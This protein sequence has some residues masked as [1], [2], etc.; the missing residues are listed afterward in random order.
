MFFVK[1][2]NQIFDEIFQIVD[3]FLLCFVFPQTCQKANQQN[4]NQ[5]RAFLS[6]SQADTFAELFLQW[7]CDHTREYHST[8]D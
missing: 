1:I 6:V 8:T 4:K 5:T 2:L 3:L 7:Y